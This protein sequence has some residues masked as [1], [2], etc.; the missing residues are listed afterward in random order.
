MGRLASVLIAMRGRRPVLTRPPVVALAIAIL[1]LVGVPPVTGPVV[2]AQSG[3]VA[4]PG[5][6]APAMAHARLLS[7]PGRDA[8]PASTK[9]TITV[10]LNRTDQ[11]GFLHYLRAVTSPQSPS[12]DQF[13][14]QAQLA[15]RFGPSQSAYDSV[16]AWLRARGFRIVRGSVNRLTI[17]ARST[18]R[19]AEHAFG[20][21]IRRYRLDGRLVYANTSDPTIPARLGSFVAAIGGLS[22]LATPQPIDAS[23][24]PAASKMK[25]QALFANRQVAARVLVRL[26]GLARRF[27]TLRPAFHQI[28]HMLRAGHATRLSR[29]IRRSLSGPAIRRFARTGIS[30]AF[31]GPGRSPGA[32]MV[33]L[34][35]GGGGGGSGGGGKPP[36]GRFCVKL[37]SCVNWTGPTACNDPL[38][39]LPHVDFSGFGLAGFALASIMTLVLIFYLNSATVSLLAFASVV[40]P[41]LWIAIALVAVVALV[42]CFKGFDGTNL[43]WPP[44]KPPKWWPKK[45]P[46]DNPPKPPKWWNKNWPWP[47]PKSKGKKKSLRNG[48]YAVSERVGFLEYDS[49]RLSDVRKWFA[50]QGQKL[51]LGAQVS[52]VSING[53]VKT[54]GAGEPEVL[55]DLDSAISLSPGAQYRVYEAATS[56][57]FEQL[58]NRMMNDG[59][60]IISNSWAQCEDQTPPAETKAIDSILAQAEAAGVTVFNGTGDSG[61]TC[62]DGSANT[63]SVP[64]D[65]P[66]A[67]A[68]GGTTPI[69]G[70]GLSYGGERWW[71]AEKT[72]PPSGQGGFGVSKIFSRPSYQN[73]LTGAKG[74]SIPDL[75]V[76]ADP[77]AGLDP[78][79]QDAGGCPT[80]LLFGGTSMA[81]PEI[82]ALIAQLEQSVDRRLHVEPPTIYR[83]A[84][85]LPGAFHTAKSMKSDF[86]HVGLGDPE[87]NAWELKFKKATTGKVSKT[88]SLAFTSAVATAGSTTPGVLRVVLVGSNGYPVGGKAVTVKQGHGSHAVI[89]AASGRSSST[90]GSVTFRI[91][92]PVAERVDLTITDA[93]DHLTLEAHPGLQFEPPPATA[94]SIAASLSSVPADG[95]TSSTI[96]VTLKNGK[97]KPAVGKAVSISEGGGHA[98]V[99]AVGAKHG[100]TNSHGQAFFSVVDLTAETVV[101]TAADVTDGDVPVPGSATVVFT[102]GSGADQCPAQ[103]LSTSK[104]FRL[105][106]F[107]S[108][109][110]DGNLNSING[111]GGVGGGDWDASGNFY[112]PDY[113]TGDIYRF[114]SRGGVASRATRITR[115]PLGA[116]LDGVAFGKNGELYAQQWFTPP[117]SSATCG[118]IYQISPKTG[119]ILRIVAE[120]VPLTQLEIDPISG[121]IFTASGFNGGPNYSNDILRIHDPGRGKPPVDCSNLSAG[122]GCSIYSTQGPVDGFTFDRNGTIYARGCSTCGIDNLTWMIDGTNSKTPGK[123]TLLDNTIPGGAAPVVLQ[124]GSGK[125]LAV[126]A[127]GDSS[128]PSTYETARVDLNHLPLKPSAIVRGGAA[129]ETRGPDGCLYVVDSNALAKITSAKGFCPYPP[130]SSEGV[131]LTLF[132]DRTSAP[133][134]SGVS[135]T[136]HA[137]GLK[138]PAGHHVTIEVLGANTQARLMT[139][140]SQGAATFTERGTHEG[141]DSLTAQTSIGGRPITSDRLYVRWTAGKHVT[142]TGL[143]LSPGE[144]RAGQTLSFVASLTDI[145]AVPSK[146][147]RGQ[148]VR[149]SIPGS[150]CTAVTNRRGLATCPL[151]LPQLSGRALV[152]AR[153][154]GSRKFLTS[155]AE[156]VITV[157]RGI[158]LIITGAGKQTG[159]TTTFTW[160]VVK[161]PTL[162][163]FNVIATGPGHRGTRV[164]SKIIK[165]HSGKSYTFTVHN[166]SWD[167]DA[168]LLGVHSSAGWQRVGP[169]TVKG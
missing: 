107:A 74:R 154:G 12:Y 159:S 141:S 20:T 108:G 88:Q 132:Q 136:V 66:H 82:A 15:D 3:R 164:N 4:V 155:S 106:P 70:P 113:I 81:A 29:L 16:L 13:L 25:W 149:L 10:T 19:Q 147:L 151:K 168:F 72:N 129:P 166:I 140:N 94:G 35:K 133:L 24:R 90:D 67:I 95:T 148:S 50:L 150:N 71:G 78:C 162:I 9:L 127:I 64:A 139:L 17:S 55:L 110:F 121:D 86:A 104:H 143:S 46:W 60:T 38:S 69:F 125:K 101:F 80:G 75:A 43:T 8:V 22:S 123:A 153:Y 165:A 163:G 99:S 115:K 62:L 73:G 114:S 58:F 100:V 130:A 68:V 7:G 119:K 32:T 158:N 41:Y 142:F 42:A 126:I 112:V 51:P 156:L 5:E 135:F 40:A 102:T 87:L 146:P 118:C 14:S 57:T 157:T 128:N 63:V 77:R 85:N 44:I 117:G 56:T 89:S 26:G 92:D 45:W 36:A 161:S 124:P 96:T 84:K 144:G 34:K 134:G 131:G 145:T 111:C 160:K 122:S 31:A 37:G 91:T 79:E 30:S 169:F 6:V 18:V 21:P 27:P 49:F 103:T 59:D 47:W 52:V 53:G 76:N 54:P 83:L 116:Y 138:K 2:G 167:V 61:S 48:L 39:A 105:V 97:D 1:L 137:N 93:T 109:F 33:P 98:I 23:T 65:S 120:N 11:A 28:M 152:R